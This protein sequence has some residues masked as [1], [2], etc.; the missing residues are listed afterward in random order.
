[1]QTPE[2]A[3]GPALPPLP[4]PVPLA[5]RPGG[6]L[7]PLRCRWLAGGPLA[8]L[9]AGPRQ[10]G[11]LGLRGWGHLGQRPRGP[12]PEG[13]EGEERRGRGCR[14]QPRQ[15]SGLCSQRE[16]GGEN[17]SPGFL[18]VSAEGPLSWGRP[19]SPPKREVKA[20]APGVTQTGG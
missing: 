16:E 2:E 13:G 12:G 20:M 10:K 19:P 1:M 9:S 18:G 8:G 4:D 3:E 11:S 15:G 5:A 7:L 17:D 6:R 14:F